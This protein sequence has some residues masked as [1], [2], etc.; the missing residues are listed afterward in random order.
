M[1]LNVWEVIRLANRHPRVNI[2]QPGP[3]VG[4]HCIAVDPW[5]IVHGAPE[6]SP[7]IRTARNVNDGKVDHVIARAAALIT[8]NPTLTVGCMGL[9]FKANIDDFRESPAMKVAVELTSRFGSRI[10]IVEPYAASLPRGFDGS[11]A[12]LIDLD[13]A[14]LECGILITLVDHDAF[15]AIP[16]AERAGKIV[17][18]VRG[19]WPDQ[20]RSMR[21]TTDRLRLAS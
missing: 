17:Y 4:G 20:P 3:G 1:D 5:F 7:L 10:S 15:K 19:I 13:T 6:Q 18:D 11:G 8:D 21:R 14:L 16:L 2:L 9:A 12:Q